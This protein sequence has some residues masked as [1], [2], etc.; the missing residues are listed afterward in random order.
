MLQQ[1]LKNIRAILCDNGYPESIIDRS[2]FNKLAQFQ[3]LSKFDPDECP[4]YLKL[5]WI[6]NISIKFK[7]KIKSS[8][9]QCFRAVEP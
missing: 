8:V 5:P 9:K 2:I 6:G 1:E 3:S 4:V 7:N